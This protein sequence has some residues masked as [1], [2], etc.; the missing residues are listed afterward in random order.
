MAENIEE[1]NEAELLEEAMQNLNIDSD[2]EV[3]EDGQELSDEDIASLLDDDKKEEVLEEVVEEV[4]E[5]PLEEATQNEPQDEI[6]EVDDINLNNSEEPV[7]T[8]EDIEIKDNAGTQKKQ[9]KLFKI[10]IIV[11]AV[12]LTLVSAG[13]VLFFLGFFDP[14]P[15]KVEVEE[16]TPKKE[17][18]KFDENDIDQKRLNKKLNLL[19]KYEIVENANT[20]AAKAEEK[21]KLYLEA[22]KQLEAERQAQIERIKEAERKRIETELPPVKKDENVNEIIEKE[23]EQVINKD[24]DIENNST[25]NEEESNDINSSQ[26]DVENEDTKQVQ[27]D[28]IVPENNSNKEE[29]ISDNETKE[30]NENIVQ[31]NLNTEVEEKKSVQNSLFI[32]VLK[33]ST[34]SDVIYKKQ[35]D[36]IYSISDNVNLCRDYQNNIE[37]FIGPFEDNIKRENIAKQ[38]K[39]R[40]NIT[41]EIADYTKEEYDNRCNY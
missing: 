35:L 29:T 1:K 37:V 14:E 39:D 20:E 25:Q 5:E 3:T 19:T 22:K 33:I 34:N 7:P 16:V 27:D 18:Y 9:S 32:K 11:A 26:I 40:F 15:V 4:K 30:S 38:Y 10:L 31:N 23:I 24:E 6:T 21:E 41:S 17:E 2:K 8:E 12:L 28:T 36:E 13:V